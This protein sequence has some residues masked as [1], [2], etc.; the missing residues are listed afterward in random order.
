MAV[1]AGAVMMRVYERGEDPSAESEISIPGWGLV[2]DVDTTGLT[3]IVADQPPV[4]VT[5]K[6]MY[7][8]DVRPSKLMEPVMEEDGLVEIVT[9]LDPIF[10]AGVGNPLSEMQVQFQA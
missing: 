8:D 4:P 2:T 7:W 3:L 1:S 9:V 5:Y 10:V 6:Y